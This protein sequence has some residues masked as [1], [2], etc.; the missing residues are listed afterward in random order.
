MNINDSTFY[1]CIS[2]GGDGGAIWFANGLNIQFLRICA[3]SCHTA[4]NK[5]YQF[6]SIQTKNIQI[7]DLISINNCSNLNGSYTIK[8]YD[9]NQSIFN[10]NI[11]NNNNIAYSGIYYAWPINMLSNYC[12]FYNK[13]VYQNS[14]ISFEFNTGSITK[15]NIIL[16]NSPD[17]GSGILF[18]S[19]GDYNLIECIFD[20]NKDILLYSISGTI[21]LIDCYYLRGSSLSYGSVTNTLIKTNTNY[22]DYPIYFT[23]YCSYKNPSKPTLNPSH[24]PSP[25]LNPT[26]EFSPTISNTFHP[27]ISST[28][29]PTFS[30]TLV[31]SITQT[32]IPQKSSYLLIFISIF[33]SIL[34]II[35]FIFFY[36]EENVEKS[37]I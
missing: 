5:N 10:T 29:N 13:T 23:Y 35:L 21:Q 30:D 17:S 37:L 7:Y 6:A 12:T 3:L 2:T 8:L 11:S 19:R 15:S 1:Q 18:L 24:P 31:P 20:Q 26:D 25:S 28:S 16:N 33:I 9:G 4:P 36:K 34:I 27:S 32:I 14:V 22:Y